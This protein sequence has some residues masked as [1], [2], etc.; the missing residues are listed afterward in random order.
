M[1]PFDILKNLK[2][3]QSKM[4][5]MQ[6]KLDTVIVTGTAGGGMAS[7][8]LNGKMEMLSL[9]ISPDIFKEDDRVM[10][11]DLVRAA[12]NDAQAKLKEQLRTE[13]S[14]VTGGMNI[15]GMDFPPGMFGA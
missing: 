9:E 5:E 12:Y 4:A 1:N 11:Q 14:S 15:P 8:T 13:F 2:N 10:L 3:V 7:V 6:A